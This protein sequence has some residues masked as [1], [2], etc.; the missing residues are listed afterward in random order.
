M[1]GFDVSKL[2]AVEGLVAVVTG[3]GSG[4][5]LCMSARRSVNI[6][7]LIG[8]SSEWRDRVHCRT[9]E[10]EVGDCC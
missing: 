9:D 6:R 3:G 8:S 1:E 10:G 7:Y 5:G 2:F 4:I